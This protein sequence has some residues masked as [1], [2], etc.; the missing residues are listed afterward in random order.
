MSD[1]EEIEAEP[2]S[3]YVLTL[4]VAGPGFRESYDITADTIQE[5]QPIVVDLN[6]LSYERYEGGGEGEFFEVRF[7]YIVA[8]NVRSVEISPPRPKAP[9]IT[10]EQALAMPAEQR[11]RRQERHEH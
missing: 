5:L 11:I 9:I 7:D 8:R 3:I 1:D 6:G 4:T 10:D 2:K